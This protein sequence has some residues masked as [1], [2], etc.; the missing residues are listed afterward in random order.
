MS[1]FIYFHN[2]VSIFFLVFLAEEF[3][4]ASA[5]QLT[6]YGLSQL[7][8]RV[9]EDELCILFRNNHFIT[10]YKYKVTDENVI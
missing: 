6:K 1:V 2:Q 4:H 10:L 9:K 8:A 5:S 7:I 3:L